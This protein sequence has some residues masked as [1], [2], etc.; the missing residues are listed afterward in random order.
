MNLFSINNAAIN[1][2]GTS[3]VVSATVTGIV[4]GA[5]MSVTGAHLLAAETNVEPNV[6]SITATAEKHHPGIA[7][8][9]GG[10][11]IQAVPTH[12]HAI[13]ANITGTAQATSFVIH[14]VDGFSNIVAGATTLAT[15]GKLGDVNLA[16]SAAISA[17]ATR[18]QNGLSDAVVGTASVVNTIAGVTTRFVEANLV[19]SGNVTS[20]YRVL[21]GGTTTHYSGTDTVGTANIATINPVFSVTTSI[22]CSA[23]TDVTPFVIQNG[24]VNLEVDSSLGIAEAFISIVSTTNLGASA[25]MVA[26]GVITRVSEST[27]GSGTANILASALQK[28]QGFADVA[29]SCAVVSVFPTHTLSASAD[30][31]HSINIVATSGRILTP[32]AELICSGTCVIK[33]TKVQ[34]VSHLV[35][36]SS[37]LIAQS[38][39]AVIGNLLHDGF[40]N[41]SCSGVLYA[42]TIANPESLDPP[43]RTFTRPASIVDFNRPA[44]TFEFRRPV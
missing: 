41:L 21:S 35:T 13:E 27:A 38:N 3:R 8:L 11:Q 19:G 37:N 22:P 10:I 20:G 7:N 16:G 15:A 29:T 39:A 18:I 5:L 30:I 44:D 17:D 1:S 9:L 43:E 32:E 40:V 23:D 31:T 6:A 28:H 34:T 2:G 14:E 4:C 42:D 12:K 36:G 24:N 33:N 26:E 25:E